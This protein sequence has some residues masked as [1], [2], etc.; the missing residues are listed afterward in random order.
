MKFCAVAF[1]SLNVFLVR[2]CPPV[3]EQ[4]I[5]ARIEA[6]DYRLPENIKPLWYNITL[7]PRLDEE[8]VLGSLQF[9][10]RALENTKNV[11]IEIRS[12]TINYDSVAL[13]NSSGSII[14]INNFT[15][16]NDTEHYVLNLDEE[17]NSGDEYTLTIGEYQGILHTDNGGFYL[18]KYVDEDGNEK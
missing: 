16:Y 8:L 18:A 17:L 12:V 4:A 1:L 7:E 5:G 3:V 9:K 2:S 6:S 11:T 15:W 14:S 13:E 10:F